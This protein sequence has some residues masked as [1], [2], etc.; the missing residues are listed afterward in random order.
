MNA[1]AER[2]VRSIKEECLDKLILF[3][4]DRLR[5]SAAG[6]RRALPRGTPH[7]GIGNELIAPDPR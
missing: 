2:F 1:F 7:Q 3:G 4:E 6:I 5:H